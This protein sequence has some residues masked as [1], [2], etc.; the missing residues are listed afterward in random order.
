MTTPISLTIDC[1][2]SAAQA[3]FWTQ[4]I[5]YEMQPPPD[6][7]ATWT[8]YWRA[9]GMSEEELAKISEEDGYNV[10]VD[11]AG[12][13]PRIWFQPVPESKVVKNRLHLD[14]NA[15]GGRSKPLEER[16]PLVDT[17]VERLEAL[18]ATVFARLHTEGLD[19]YG[20]VMQDPEGNEFC[21]S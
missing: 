4:A 18:G 12:V 16:I 5:H 9:K 17:E 2:N 21:V 1:I 3:R 11:P 20:V 6:G 8:D 10:I 14:L 19:H 15:S 13:G 7:S